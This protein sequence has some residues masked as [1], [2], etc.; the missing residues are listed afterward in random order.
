M[1]KISIDISTKQ[2]QQLDES[3][4]EKGYTVSSWI[5]EQINLAIEEVNPPKK[6]YIS[7]GVESLID[8]D[9]AFTDDKTSIYTHDLHPYPAKFIPQIPEN[10]ILALSKEGD[11]VLD[12]FSGS[13]TTATESSRLGRSSISI[14]ANPL[15]ALIGKAKTSKIFSADQVELNGLISHINSYLP[16]FKNDASDEYFTSIIEKNIRYI[17]VIPN[18]EKWFKLYVKAEL[19]I[20]NAFVKQLTSKAASDLAKV[21]LSRIVIRVSNQDSETRYTSVQNKVKPSETLSLFLTNLDFVMKKVKLSMK[22]FKYSKATFLSGD[23][24]EKMSDLDANSVDLIVTSP[25][26]ANSTDYHL[27][28]RFRMFWLGFDPRELG[29]IEIGSHLKHQRNNSGYQEYA[30]DMTLVLQGMFRVLKPG[31]YAALVVGDSIFKDKVYETHDILSKVSKEI[32]F[33]HNQ[34]IERP[35]HETKRSFT[36][37]GRRLRKEQIVILKKPDTNLNISYGSSNYKLF[38]YEVDLLKS[39]INSL[40][41]NKNVVINQDNKKLNFEFFDINSE[42]IH[43]L[44]KLS[45]IHEIRLS[46]QEIIKTNQAI[47]EKSTQSVRKNSTYFSHGLHSYKGKF[48]PQLAKSLLN[49]AQKDRQIIKVL[50]PFCGSGTSILESVMSN[51]M[52]FGLD[53]NPIAINITRAKNEI[54]NISNEIVLN[55]FS[56][57]ENNLLNVIDPPEETDQFGN[58][59]LGEIFSWFP[60]K[61]V[62]KLNYLLTKIR[63]FGNEQIINYFEVL[64]S[65]IIRNISQQEPKDLRIRR[66]KEPIEDAPVF[67]LY[68]KLLQKEKK[69]LEHYW[70]A[71][72]QGAIDYGTFT[73]ALCDNRDFGSYLSIGLTENS[74]DCIVT[75]P[76]YATALPYIDTDRLSILIINQLASGRRAVIERSNRF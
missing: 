71:K 48:Y 56:T 66:R 69:K 76:P 3:L 7:G 32:G 45:F 35:L 11:I 8:V 44:K 4:K 17:P 20:I 63:L 34:T 62:Y 49:I 46:D 74:I 31:K 50:D 58:E 42:K 51:N 70:D 10:L 72:D 52:T 15:S 6:N 9:W 13:C 38:D 19:S 73:V 24:R 65:S 60:D 23:S 41:S 12:P 57:I 75:S 29:K 39:E 37:P 61:V 33:E 43:L 40:F 68:L 59:L 1:T 2:K 36:K 54:L 21:A 16:T 26:Y 47:K 18:E 25:P 53:M 5:S 28:H 64:V 55:S 30:D 27:Y 14:D 67:E 22:S